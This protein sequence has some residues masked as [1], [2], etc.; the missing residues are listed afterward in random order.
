M[1][2]EAVR[3]LVIVALIVSANM[4]AYGF[5]RALRGA[6]VRQVV[7]PPF[8]STFLSVL[9]LITGF[10]YLGVYA[11]RDDYVHDYNAFI[12][13][14]AVMMSLSSALIVWSTRRSIR[15]SA[16]GLEVQYIFKKDRI[17][18]WKE[19]K[20]ICRDVMSAT[21]MVN[22]RDGRKLPFAD[23]WDNLDYL[24]EFA[25]TKQI[26][27]VRMSPTRLGHADRYAGEGDNPANNA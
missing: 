12:R 19:I 23:S 6:Y 16:R 26:R 27:L 11:L 10:I 1:S 24:W 17:I 4:L 3:T 21:V 9:A 18:P 15:V 25:E 20:T 7:R 5:S 14:L 22:T 8:S 2:A 13:P